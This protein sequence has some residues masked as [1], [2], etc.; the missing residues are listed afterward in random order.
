MKKI[1]LIFLIII[2][3]S[4][5]ETAGPN[6]ETIDNNLMPLKLNNSWTYK[7]IINNKTINLSIDS[8]IYNYNYNNNILDKIYIFSNKEI[9]CKNN[10]ILLIGNLQPFLL[11]DTFLNLDTLNYSYNSITN[12]LFSGYYEIII[13]N[14]NY[15]TACFEYIY[16][17]MKYTK[18]YKTGIGLIKEKILNI[19]SN[20][21]IYDVELINYKLN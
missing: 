5:K 15:K 11:F 18:Y 14:T 10:N 4:C 9:Y 7:D 6:E 13:N 20:K 2:F 1:Y 21:I 8:I 3:A 12:K 16:L 17:N 19:S